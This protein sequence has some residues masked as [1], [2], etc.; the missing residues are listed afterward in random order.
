M[1]DSNLFSYLLFVGF[2]GANCD[3][4]CRMSACLDGVCDRVFGYCVCP[5]GSYGEMC[6]KSCPPFT[7]GKNCR[8]RC[9][10][11]KE[12]TDSCDAKVGCVMQVVAV[13]G[14]WSHVNK[15]QSSF[16]HATPI[17][18]Q[19]ITRFQQYTQQGDEII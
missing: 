12:N 16:R 7:H 15:V 1:F 4:P 3:L 6:E 11:N 2:Y 18:F 10:C 17:S 9:R 8:H 14:Y 5:V 19:E 13:T